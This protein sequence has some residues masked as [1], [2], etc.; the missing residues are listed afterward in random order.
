MR[1]AEVVASILTAEEMFT[2]MCTT[3]VF[4]PVSAQDSQVWEIKLRKRKSISMIFNGGK[5]YFQMTGYQD[6][7][8]K[9][10]LSPWQG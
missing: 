10:T 8:G 2:W 7:C 6:K 1:F 4:L 3:R 5:V 9:I